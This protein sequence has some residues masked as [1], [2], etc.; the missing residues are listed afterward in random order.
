MITFDPE[1]PWEVGQEVTFRDDDGC[2]LEVKV[3]A[4]VEQRTGNRMTETQY[5]MVDR[6]VWALHQQG[7]RPYVGLD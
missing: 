5:Q 3:V 4:S 7:V 1:E 2:V 6:R